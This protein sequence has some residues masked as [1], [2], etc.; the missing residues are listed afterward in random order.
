M[1]KFVTAALASLMVAGVLAGT[2]ETA[3]KVSPSMVLMVG[4]GSSS[5]LA[6]SPFAESYS[7]IMSH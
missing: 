3:L 4:D 2:N 1:K 6:S 5:V 7:D